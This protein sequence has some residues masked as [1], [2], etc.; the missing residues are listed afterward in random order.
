MKLRNARLLVGALTFLL[1]L[2]PSGLAV[3]CAEA[4]VG[5]RLGETGIR[6]EE[7]AAVRS[8]LALAMKDQAVPAFF[9]NARNGKVPVVLLNGKTYPEVK[10]YV[11]NS[12]GTQVYLQPNWKNDHGGI[13]VLGHLIDVDLPGY[14]EYG[15]IHGT[16]LAWKPLESYVNRGGRSVIVEVS[17]YLTPREKAVADYYHR[18]RRAALYRV[19]F[20]FGNAQPDLQ[21]A[22]MLRNGGEHCFV[23]CK[24]SA[25]NGHVREMAQKIGAFGVEDLARY[26]QRPEVIDFIDQA[27]EL[28]ARVDPKKS[29]GPDMLVENANIQKSLEAIAPP[30]VLADRQELRNFGNLLIGYDS[31]QKYSELMRALNVSSD[32]GFTD[33]DNPRV[34]AI[35]IYDNDAPAEAFF[36]ASYE[37]RGAFSTWRNEG[38][39]VLHPPAAWP[40]KKA[41]LPGVP[42][43]NEI[44]PAVPLVKD[45]VGF[46]RRLFGR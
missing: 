21:Q 23:F 29:L 20:T 9:K 16:G 10:P 32:V 46:F 3:T 14:R 13:R 31:A 33:L 44:Q 27:R 11:E 18:V 30:G 42:E 43:G 8:G 4:F 1:A 24:A 34:T 15:E 22:N 40:V 38:Q 28:I 17:Y 39:S 35:L 36:E 2:P 41:P 45:M 25:V 37:A 7:V 26:M 12:L 6:A 19:P 5:L